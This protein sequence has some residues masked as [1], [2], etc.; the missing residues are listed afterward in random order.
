MGQFSFTPADAEAEQFCWKIVRFLM[1]YG[2]SKSEALHRL[3]EHWKGQTIGGKENCNWIVY[4][5][6]ADE[7]AYRIF[8]GIQKI[9]EARWAAQGL[10]PIQPRSNE[11]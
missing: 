9:N 4:H 10:S 3:N 1:S 2:I 6:D 5:L 8:Y 7:W 11:T